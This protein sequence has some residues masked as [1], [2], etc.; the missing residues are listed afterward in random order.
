MGGGRWGRSKHVER[1]RNERKSAIASGG[2]MSKK[3]QKPWIG[4]APRSQCG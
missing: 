3:F 1:Q 2:G 4:K